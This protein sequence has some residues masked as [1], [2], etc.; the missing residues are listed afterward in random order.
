M[1]KYEG[2]DWP[3]KE[4]KPTA[5]QVEQAVADTQEQPTVFFQHVIITLADGRRGVFMGPALINE[6]EMKLHV[7]PKL[8]SVDFDPPRAVVVPSSR[9]TPKTEEIINVEQTPDN[10]NKSASKA[11]LE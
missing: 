5:E 1:S 3:A 2:Q 6:V 11:G 10:P 9:E 8:V 4:H 7:V